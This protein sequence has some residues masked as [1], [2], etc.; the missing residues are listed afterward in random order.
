MRSIWLCAKNVFKL[1][2]NWTE[3]KQELY[4]WMIEMENNYEIK[5]RGGSM[6]FYGEWFGRPYDNFHRVKRASII[7]D[8]LTI[9]FEGGEI[10][11][12][13]SPG[14]IK[15]TE[16][17]FIIVDAESI[18]WTWFYYERTQSSEI[19]RGYVYQKKAN[20]SYTKSFNGKEVIFHPKEPVA[21]KMCGY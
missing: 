21:V 9:Q 6:C 7:N 3:Q 13:A 11:T 14:N 2:G 18:E 10:L 20:G 16:K 17:E 1:S 19:H 15:N 5:M 8:T 12:A 4:D